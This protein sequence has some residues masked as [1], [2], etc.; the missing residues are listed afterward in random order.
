MSEEL[1]PCPFCGNR[2]LALIITQL[3]D[4]PIAH[5]YQCFCG[6]TGPSTHTKAQCDRQW[7]HRADN[8]GEGE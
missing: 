2:K 6:A 1:K 8:R 4:G 3:G 5:Q 7:N